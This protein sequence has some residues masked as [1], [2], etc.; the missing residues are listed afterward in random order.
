MGN[1]QGGGKK[2][3][4]AASTG[5]STVQTIGRLKKS[6]NTLEQREKHLDRQILQCLKAYEFIFFNFIDFFRRSCFFL[7]RRLIF[8]R[9]EQ[10]KGKN[11]EKR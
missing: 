3:T 11:E 8:K 9:N 7:S 2:R 10:G 4:P 6:Q 5:S 1:Q